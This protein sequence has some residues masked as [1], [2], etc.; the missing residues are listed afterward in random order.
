MSFWR[1]VSVLA[2]VVVLAGIVPAAAQTQGNERR[3]ERR[4]SRSGSRAVKQACKAGDEKSRSE[5][6]HMKHQAKHAEPHDVGSN[7]NAAPAKPSQ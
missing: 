5:C 3:E 4:E 7:A 6:R 1:R 2:A